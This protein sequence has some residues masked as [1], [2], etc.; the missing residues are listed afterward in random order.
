MIWWLASR[1]AVKS[2]D[3]YNQYKQII[4]PTSERPLA[5][6]ATQELA[7]YNSYAA[8]VNGNVFTNFYKAFRKAL[9]ADWKS[10]SVSER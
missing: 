1:A 4:D 6:I 2:S 7:V 9:T 5:P 8:V 10:K 3:F